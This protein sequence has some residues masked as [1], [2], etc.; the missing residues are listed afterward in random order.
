MPAGN[1]SAHHTT[2]CTSC[3]GLCTGSCTKTA[4]FRMIEPKTKALEARS[5]PR[6]GAPSEA[7][8]STREAILAAAETIMT[9]EGYAAV[10]SRRVAEKAGLKS[11]LVHYYFGTMD[12]LF[13]AVYER[14]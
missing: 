10:T 2:P 11:Q 5:R 7:A 4:S 8:A 12:E 9:E 14:S 6:A 3:T 1:P 13:V